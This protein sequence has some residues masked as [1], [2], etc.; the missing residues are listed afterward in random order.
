MDCSYLFD[1]PSVA[2]SLR[3]TVLSISFCINFVRIMPLWK[4]GV[5]V[6]GEVFIETHEHETITNY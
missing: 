3:P 6:E 1:F 4:H 5:C 2:N